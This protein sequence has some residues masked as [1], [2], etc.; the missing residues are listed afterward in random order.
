MPSPG[1]NVGSVGTITKDLNTGAVP[2]ST[3]NV[4]GDGF[5]YNPG[6][7]RQQADGLG[8]MAPI[9]WPDAS[10][11]DP[12]SFAVKTAGAVAGSG[13]QNAGTIATQGYYDLLKGGGDIKTGAQH[14]KTTIDGVYNWGASARQWHDN[15]LVPWHD[16]KLVPA[17][18]SFANA[19][20]NVFGVPINNAHLSIRHPDVLP[21]ELSLIHI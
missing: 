16:N 13:L 20:T 3:F 17:V 1:D 15:T 19:P 6:Y 10:K 9:N 7:Y 2:T 18:K 5:N 21:G 14:A 4:S 8:S 11:N 12:L